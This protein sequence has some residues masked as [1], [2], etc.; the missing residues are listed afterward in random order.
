MLDLTIIYLLLSMVPAIEARGSTIFLVCSN[1]WML[2]PIAVALN[3]FATLIFVYIVNKSS[4]PNRLNNFFK[5]RAEK[6]KEK[7]DRLFAKYGNVAVFLLV[8]VPSTGIGSFTGALIGRMMGLKGKVFYLSILGGIIIS[9]I[10][11]LLLGWGIG[12]L[13]ITCPR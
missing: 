10:P 7:A 4:L 6:R 1:Q 8:G 12:M 2:I 13:G 9:L 11:A 3:F 5:K